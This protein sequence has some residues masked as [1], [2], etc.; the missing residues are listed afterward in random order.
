[1]SLPP[2][3][4]VKGILFSDY[5]RMIKSHKAVPWDKH[6]ATQDLAL[7]EKK[8]DP[9]GWYPME[10]FERMGNA[11]LR[12]IANENLLS[13]R[14][15]GRLSVEQLRAANPTLVADGDPRE[16]LMRFKVY[17]ATFFD[18]DALE[19]RTIADDHARIVIRYF[20]EAYAEEA[21]SF[22]TMGFFEQLLEIAGARNVEAEFKAKSW[23]GADETILELHWQLPP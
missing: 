23:L 15:W 5:V 6:L 20:M 19:V 3:R 11:I 9:N 12:E 2:S 1:L 10:S 22:Q 17:R 7:L 14:A 16:T 8:I 18:F 13:V 21:A 4:N